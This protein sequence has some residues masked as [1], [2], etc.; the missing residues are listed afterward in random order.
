MGHDP[1]KIWRVVGGV[2]DYSR[3]LE[4]KKIDNGSECGN[5]Y[6]LEE[7]TRCPEIPESRGG[8]DL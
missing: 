8:E 3:L 1:L 6:V 5:R 4:R 7:G 2:A